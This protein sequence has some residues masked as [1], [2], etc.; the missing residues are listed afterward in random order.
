MPR[1]ENDFYPTPARATEV[2]LEYVPELAYR[3]IAGFFEPCAGDGA[4]ARVLEEACKTTK[5]GEV[6]A[7]DIDAAQTYPKYLCDARTVKVLR[8]LKRHY[9]VITNPPF[10]QAHEIVSNF[11]DQKL[12]C[13]FLLRLSFLEPTEK[14]GPWL[15]EHPPDRVI[16]LPRISFTGDSKTDSVTCAWMCWN[17]EPAPL[18]VVPKSKFYKR[19]AE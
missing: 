8:R 16:V 3:S 17:V 14:R 5:V 9:T 10:N 11:V 7:A 4:I 1:R 6:V 2:L 15:A 12:V 13:A 18:A 19:G